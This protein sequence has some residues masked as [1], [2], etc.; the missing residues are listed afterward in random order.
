MPR[1]PWLDDELAE[2][3]AIRPYQP[4]ALVRF[5]QRHGRNRPEVADKLR[6]LRIRGEAADTGCARRNPFPKHRFG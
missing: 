6:H 2:L 3:R 4:G 5:A 1:R